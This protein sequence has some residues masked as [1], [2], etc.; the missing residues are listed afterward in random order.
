MADDSKNQKRSLAII[1]LLA[2]ILAGAISFG[3]ISVLGSEVRRYLIAALLAL[4][5]YLFLGILDNSEATTGGPLR[6]LIFL[7]LWGSFMEL[8]NLFPWR[9]GGHPFNPLVIPI[10]LAGALVGAAIEKWI[11]S[12]STSKVPLRPE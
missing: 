5:F 7:A 8:L 1:C 4:S 6:R 3:G 2:T 11:R 12:I 10:F 9:V